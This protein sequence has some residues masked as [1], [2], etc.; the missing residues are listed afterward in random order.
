VSPKGSFLVLLGVLGLL[1]AIA[2]YRGCS[3][4]NHPK[5]PRIY[6]P[7]KETPPPRSDIPLVR[8]PMAD[9]GR[10][11]P[12]QTSTEQVGAPKRIIA[13]EGA[14][15]APTASL[16]GVVRLATA[17]SAPATQ[18]LAGAPSCQNRHPQG[19]PDES[20]LVDSDLGLQNAVVWILLGS[21][22]APDSIPPPAA[23]SLDDCRFQPRVVVL[24]PEQSFQVRNDDDLRHDLLRGTNENC[25]LEPGKSI[26][27][28][29]SGPASPLKHGCQLHPWEVGWVVVLPTRLHDL[30]MVGGRFRIEGIPLGEHGLVVWHERCAEVLRSL[31]VSEPGEKVMDIVLPT[32]H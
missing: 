18:S 27:T 7:V 26:R 4:D 23:M 3:P 2:V 9:G 25:P 5:L 14:S 17:P 32:P 29:W 12:Q 28:R 31:L 22:T 24:V 8:V 10:A 11:L 13:P 1:V 16:V 15:A 30:T 6:P 19:R 21:P 20:L